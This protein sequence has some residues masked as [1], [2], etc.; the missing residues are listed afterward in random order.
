MVVVL[1]STR[2]REDVD[3]ADHS[4]TSARMREPVAE[5]PGFISYNTYEDQ[6]GEGVAVARLESHAARDAWRKNLEHIEAHGAAARRH[7]R[8]KHAQR[9]RLAG[10]VGAEKTEDLACL[11]A[12]VHARDRH[13]L[14]LPGLEDTA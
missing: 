5:I 7:E 8:C 11:H 9:R 1:F 2:G 10:A 6:N 12:Q 14:A 4:R 3:I 13:D